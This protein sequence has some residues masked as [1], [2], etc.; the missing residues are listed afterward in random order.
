M[1]QSLWRKIGSEA[2]RFIRNKN[3]LFQR[4]SLLIFIRFYAKFESVRYIRTKCVLSGE[5]CAKGSKGSPSDRRK[6][7][8]NLKFKPSLNEIR[9]GLSFSAF[10]CKREDSGKNVTDDI[11][12]PAPR[13][14]ARKCRKPVQRRSQGGDF[15]AMAKNSCRIQWRQSVS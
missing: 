13:L 2:L 6:V 3:Q 14:R 7:S 10:C 11:R 5:Q 8:R 4:I 15:C 9:G 12:H 1:A